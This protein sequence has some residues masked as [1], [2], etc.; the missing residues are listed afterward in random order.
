MRELE[1]TGKTVEEATEKAILELGVNEDEVD[2]EI[3]EEGSRGIFGLGAKQARVKVVVKSNPSAV[4]EKVLSDILTSMNLDVK[5]IDKKE[6]NNIVRFCLS[7][8]S[9]GILIGRHG[10]TL[11][12]LQLLLNIIANKE[13]KDKKERIRIVVDGEGYRE[14]REQTLQGLAEKMARKAY[15]TKK[16]IVLEPMLP[17]ER[18]IIHTVLQDNPYVNTYS[19]GDEPVRR[20][21]ISPR[22]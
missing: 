2:I 13:N 1:Q 15:E 21:V 5:I 4:A 3:L 9:L 7:G 22:K 6:E 20:V 18:R 16:N 10:R 17:Y 14:R 19:Q 12:S 8:D 11:D